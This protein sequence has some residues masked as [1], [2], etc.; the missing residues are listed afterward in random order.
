L[1]RPKPTRLPDEQNAEFACDRGALDRNARAS[2]GRRR[3]RG[4]LAFAAPDRLSQLDD[5]IEASK[6]VRKSTYARSETIDYVGFVD[7]H[8]AGSTIDPQ[9]GQRIPPK[10]DCRFVDKGST[11]IFGKVEALRPE[12]FVKIKWTAPNL[13]PGTI[14]ICVAS[15]PDTRGLDC[16]DTVAPFKNAAGLWISTYWVVADPKSIMRNFDLPKEEQK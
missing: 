7:R 1:K 5:A 9:F 11:D 6:I 13:P 8:Q 2:E 16:S 14:A 3:N 12:F 10:G 4:F 15:I